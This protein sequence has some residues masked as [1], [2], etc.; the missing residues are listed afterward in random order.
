MTKNETPTLKVVLTYN[1]GDEVVR[2]LKSKV[3]S[4][5]EIFLIEEIIFGDL[6]DAKVLIG[7][8]I[9]KEILNLAKNLKY[10]IVPWS[11]INIVNV[12]EILKYHPQIRIINSHGNA[13]TVA[14]YAL[15][16]LMAITKKIVESDRYLR[17]GDWRFRKVPSF[18][19]VGKT[20]TILGFGAIARKFVEL[21][22]GFRCKINVIKRDPTTF[23]NKYR[24]IVNFIG[25]RENLT[26]ILPKT[27]Y[28][29]IMMPLTKATEGYIGRKEIE[30]LKPTSIIVNIARGKIIDE[31]ALYDA[32]VQKKI[33][34]A[35]LDVWYIYP[36]K[37]SGKSEKNCAPS[38][39][40]FWELDNVV[41][42]PHRAYN[43]LERTE[44]HWQDVVNS[45]NDIAQGKTPK[46]IV[47][48]TIGY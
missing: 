32:L 18:P 5:V 42:S 25:G 12:D 27:D 28:L 31:K 35:A 6:K 38:S 26:D 4:N 43:C 2:W 23:P 20:I 41:M 21:I 30:L 40:P 13:L 33:A 8:K 37:K 34:A 11:G 17:R 29:M 16:L 22:Q 39:F 14:E 24:N 15:A 48:L 1:P 36:G 10:V 45:L 7:G 47:N 3:S 9:P 19:V 44:L 46:N